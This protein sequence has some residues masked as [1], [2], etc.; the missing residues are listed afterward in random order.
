MPR[1]PFD[2]KSKEP[3]K[4]SRTKIEDFIRCP[5]CFYLDVK[6]GISRPPS[7]PFTLNNAVDFLLKKEFDIHR[8]KEEP[9]PLMEHYKIDAVP[10]KHKLLDQWRDWG[11]KYLHQPTNLIIF[12]KV[13]DIWIDKDRNFIVVDY[14]ATSINGEVTLDEEYKISY[15]RQVEIYQW[16]FKR[17]GFLVS[18]TAYFVYVN[19]LKDRKAFDGKLEFDVKILSYKGNDEWIEPTLLK[20]KEVLM[21]NEL[22]EFAPD[23]DFC[24]YRKKSKDKEKI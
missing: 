22:P 19:A 17:N 23:C 11:I 16:L 3:F 20:I 14:K 4:L 1:A 13:D 24:F 8:A 15:K 5:R 18:D 10:L 21:K 7:Y 2:P 12:G 6:L 9:H